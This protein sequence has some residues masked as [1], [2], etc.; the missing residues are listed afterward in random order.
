MFQ[1]KMMPKDFIRILVYHDIEKK[2]LKTYVKKNYV[3]IVRQLQI[4]VT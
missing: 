4:Q 1:K 3:K 2:D